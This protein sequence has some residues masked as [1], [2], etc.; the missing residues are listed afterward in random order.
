M[1]SIQIITSKRKEVTIKDEHGRNKT[2][3]VQVWNETVSNLTL[4]VKIN[5][6][7]T[8][9]RYKVTIFFNHLIT[10]NI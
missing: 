7:Q 1:D 10:C 5:T 2:I 4:M 9:F 3:V 6:G 8:C